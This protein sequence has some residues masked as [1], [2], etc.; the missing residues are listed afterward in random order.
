MRTLL[1]LACLLPSAAL[2]GGWYD[3]SFPHRTELKVS[4]PTV[5]GATVDWPIGVRLDATSIDWSLV[6]KNGNDLLFVDPRSGRPVPYD[7]DRFDYAG[8][9]ALIWVR[10]PSLS[11][12][13]SFSL[14]VYY[15]NP[16]AGPF[17]SP[18]ETFQ[19]FYLVH[20]LDQTGTSFEDSSPF[21]NHGFPSGSGQS[22]GS[23]IG[24]GWEFTGDPIMLNDDVRNYMGGV[25]EFYASYWTVAY[26]GGSIPNGAPG[27]FGTTRNT[28]NGI[29]WGLV[30]PNG[31][32]WVY[33]G[34]LGQ[35]SAGPVRSWTHVG[36]SFRE[37]SFHATFNNGAWYADDSAYSVPN[38]VTID[39]IGGVVEDG[40]LGGDRPYYGGVDEFRIYNQAIQDAFPAALDYYGG[41]GELVDPCASLWTTYP[42]LDGDGRGDESA[43]PTTTC[44]EQL[45]GVSNNDDCD[46]SDDTVYLGAAEQC[47]GKDNDCNGQTDEN[48]GGNIWYVD[49]D[50]DGWG[51]GAGIDSCLEPSNGS[52]SSLSGDCDDSD[53]NNYPNN[54]ETCEPGLLSDQLD[55]NCDGSV[56]DGLTFATIYRDG[57]N[58]GLGDPSSPAQTC[59]AGV[60][61]Y[62]SNGDDCD[63][64]D[65]GV[66][67]RTWYRDADGDGEGTASQ[68]VSSCTLPNGYADNTLDCDDGNSAVN[69]TT[70]W[71][72]DADRDGYGVVGSAYTQCSQQNST[73]VLQAGDCDDTDASRNPDTQWYADTDQDGYGDPSA[74]W[75][76]AQCTQPSGYVTNFG[77]CNDNDSAINPTSVWYRDS[78][79]DGFGNTNDAIVQCARP[80]GY[81]SNDFDCDD[82]DASQ[83]PNQLWYADTDSDGYGDPNNSRQDC[84]QP[85]GYVLDN[86]DC[87]DSN[88]DVN[89]GTT[90]FADGDG[91]GYGDA[92]NAV[93]TGQCTSPGGSAVPNRNDCDDSDA[94]INPETQWYPD[95]D[96]DSF[97][98]GTPTQT[99]APGTGNWSLNNFDCDDNDATNTPNQIFYEDLDGDGWGNTAVSRLDCSAPQGWVD[100]SGDCD[101]D[102][103]ATFPGGFEFC[104]DGIDGDCDG[105]GGGP[106]ADD[107]GDGLTFAEEVYT[108]DC[109]T[110]SDNDGV[111]D[112][113]EHGLNTDGDALVDGIDP[114]DDGDGI[115]TRDEDYCLS[116]VGGTCSNDYAPG[117]GDPT[118]DD[119]DGD[120]IPNY[121]DDDDDGDGIPTAQEDYCVNSSSSCTDDYGPGDG[122]PGNDFTD[123]D[124]APDYLDPDDDGDGAPTAS[125]DLNGDG[126]W[127]NDD[128][129]GDG[130]PTYLDDDEIPNLDADEDGLTDDEE[131]LIGS[132]PNLADSDGDGIS[133]L[134][135]VGDPTDPNDS[136][137]DGTYDVL[138]EDD[139]GD[140]IPT[141]VEGD[142]DSDGDGTPDF[143]DEDS[144]NDTL[145]D[146]Q[147]A[148]DDPTNPV[149]TDGDGT[150]DYLDLDSD[151]DFSADSVDPAPLDNGAGGPGTPTPPEGY[152]CGC[153]SSTPAPS[154]W[155]GLVGLL[156]LRRR[157]A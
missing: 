96:G 134:D 64:G 58:D 83:V 145:P 17:E 5:S 118:N 106:D 100:R 119:T 78:D 1:A 144:D 33:D 79:G 53:S 116:V 85:T 95:L 25:M 50:V 86:T 55:N 84:N 41:L 92:S 120:G 56:T 46:D 152:G 87:N 4:T 52:Y 38:F 63:D 70:T 49:A 140:G 71:Y 54:E 135:E 102:D 59:S 21:G 29:A 155:F 151:N 149:D 123:N 126:N 93:A 15:G 111:P 13:D 107:D 131:A 112:D 22:I 36:F 72:T 37:N 44:W 7:I 73:D 68:T 77:D 2:A 103:S 121:L 66:G 157:R 89:P 28:G 67:T 39:R 97:G 98:A 45:D 27:M 18:Q 57:D 82:T 3:P 43:P 137:G 14:Y 154:L 74:A 143:L 48:I 128:G 30:D 60:S 35:V 125:E 101:D 146:S 109:Y 148:G 110:D 105:V 26:D 91:D 138:D 12:G 115:P 114:D 51:S 34:N 9:S 20:H 130:I 139:D 132:D 108:S 94:A 47:D 75:P 6:D 99:C 88:T 32:A 23:P 124:S 65:S 16:N 150:P 127:L 31:E 147:E 24:D 104:G 113:V 42:D 8:Q 61:G 11:P 122:A 19:D 81:V 40:F 141:A 80:Q 117:E 90:W 76:T 133:D 129:D 62:V 69:S 142:G 10:L 156:A 136:D 153:Q